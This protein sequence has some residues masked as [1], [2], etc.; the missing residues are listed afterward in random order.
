M[1]PV[2][3]KPEQREALLTSLENMPTYLEATVR[4]L[5]PALTRRRGPNDGF[6]PVEQVWHLADLEREAFAVRIKRLLAESNPQ[7]PDFDGAAVA[8]ARQYRTLSPAEGLAA[9]R[10]ARALN[11]HTLR[12]LT[13]DAWDRSG[14][15][16][17]IGPVSLADVLASMASHDAAHRDE[18]EEWKRQVA[19]V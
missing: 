2:P 19:A 16:D 4:A 9:F 17:G 1:Q 13:P 7:L 15:Q 10:E 5:T 6:S 11:L 8:A 3:L 14:R 12:M 18:L